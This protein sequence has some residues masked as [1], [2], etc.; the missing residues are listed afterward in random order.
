LPLRVQILPWACAVGLKQTHA[1]KTE[2]IS[3]NLM[4][5]K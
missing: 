3:S 1:R 4:K 2:R 5:L